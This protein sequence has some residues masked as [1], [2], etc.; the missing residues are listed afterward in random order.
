VEDGQALLINC[1]ELYNRTSTIDPHHERFGARFMIGTT[2]SLKNLYKD[3][4][5]KLIIGTHV[6]NALITS[7]IRVDRTFDP[8]LGPS[9][10]LFTPSTETKVY[11]SSLNIEQANFYNFY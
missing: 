2:P 5:K 9:T 3:N 6:F 7:S 11:I 10:F 8:E 1:V 4:S